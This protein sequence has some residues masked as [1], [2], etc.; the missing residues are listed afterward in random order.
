MSNNLEANIKQ[1][2]KDSG[3]SGEVSAWLVTR[4]FFDTPLKMCREELKMIFAYSSG[5]KIKYEQYQKIATIFPEHFE[6]MY[7][8]L[9]DYGIVKSRKITKDGL[10]LAETI[11]KKL[12]PPANE[13]AKYDFLNT[14]WI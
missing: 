5:E 4:A 6:Q 11:K 12:V 1:A 7:N 13:S 8:H 2:I 3:I 14:P 9:R 10:K